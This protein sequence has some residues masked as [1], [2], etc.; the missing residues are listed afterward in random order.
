M[1]H[2]SS[3]MA[4]GGPDVLVM[5][6]QVE[7]DSLLAE[8]SATLLSVHEM[9]GRTPHTSSEAPP[10]ALALRGPC[11]TLTCKLPED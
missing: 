7:A 4:G 1:L 8:V 11:H 6:L 10:E 5:H 2:R 3:G 9:A